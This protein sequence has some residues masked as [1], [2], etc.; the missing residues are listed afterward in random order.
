MLAEVF[1]E[2]CQGHNRYALELLG[3][4]REE[5]GR[6]EIEL[7]RYYEFN[8]SVWTFDTIVKKVPVIEF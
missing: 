1:I 7:E 4:F 3:K 5:M 6:R 2:K 8:L